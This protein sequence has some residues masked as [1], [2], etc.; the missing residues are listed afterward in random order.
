MKRGFTLLE[1]MVAS[2]LLAMLVTII[3]MIFNQS[4]IAWRTGIASV[5]ELGDT[6]TCV[7]EYQEVVDDI[8]PGVGG[9]DVRYRTVSVWKRDNTLRDGTTVG[10]V[11][12]SGRPVAVLPGTVA[13]PSYEDLKKGKF[14]TVTGVGRGQSSSLYIV[15][16][17]SLGKDGRP[18]TE[19]DITTW[20]EGVD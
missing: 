10:T 13:L 8:L 15:G 9:Q 12:Q 5:V 19:D 14:Q 2:I 7:S 4:S 11:E 1:L 18:N 3:T 17:R 20:P 6:R 16:V